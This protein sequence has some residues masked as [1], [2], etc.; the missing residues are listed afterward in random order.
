MAP[1]SVNVTLRQLQALVNVA[2]MG[3]LVAA[4]RVLQVTP[5][6]LS[7]L[8]GDLEQALGPDLAVDEILPSLE[9]GRADRAV[10]RRA[11]SSSRRAPS[12]RQAA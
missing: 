8:I 10:T 3:R 9:A 1:Q 2:Q 11:A 6:A 5:S 7:M 12:R 4:A